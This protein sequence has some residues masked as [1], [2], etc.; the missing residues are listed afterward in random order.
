MDVNSVFE[1]KLNTEGIVWLTLLDSWLSQFV[2]ASFDWGGCSTTHQSSRI[3]PPAFVGRQ[4]YVA[5]VW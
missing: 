1:V 5:L 3:G 4:S 2:V